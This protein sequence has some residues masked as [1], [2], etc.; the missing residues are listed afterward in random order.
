MSLR[1]YASMDPILL[2]SLVNTELRNQFDGSLDRLV[3]HYEIDK[4]ILV[5]TL[6]HHG[7]NFSEEVGQ[8]R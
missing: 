7:F 8:F 1:N 6:V 3:S 4:E 5:N 2:F